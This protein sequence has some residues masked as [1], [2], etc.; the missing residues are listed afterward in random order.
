MDNNT[1]CIYTD[2]EGVHEE[3]YSYDRDNL[4]KYNGEKVDGYKG[5]NPKT[6]LGNTLTWA[7]GRQ[8]MSV[9]PAKKR[10]E[11]SASDTVIFTYAYDGS[12]LSKTV[13]KTKKNPGTTTEYILNGSTILAQNTTYPDGSKETLNFYYCSDG[14]LI[15]IG[16]LDNTSNDDTK[17]EVIKETHYSVIRNAMGDV[18]AIYTADGTL[19]GTYEYDPFGRLMSE[20]SN[21]SYTDTDD[22]LHK[23]P[24]RYRG[25]YYDQETKWYYLQS[26][27]YDPQVK[28]F[29]NADST[30]LLTTDNVNI[31]QYNLFMYCNGDPVNGVDPSG[32]EVVALCVALEIAYNILGTVAIIAIFCEISSM[33]NQNIIMET[34][35]I[36]SDDPVEDW[37]DDESPTKGKWSG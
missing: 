28:R 4:T 35:H 16:Y 22:I 17:T 6:Y 26:R 3:T 21:P 13:G 18:V 23:N 20:T 34:K 33:I 25:Y 19:V 11:Y 10:S 32:H 5:G 9:T 37:L 2:E 31:M 1:S 27:Y 12:R 30:D 24:F 8:L 15:E 29:I 14:K 36:I 7:R